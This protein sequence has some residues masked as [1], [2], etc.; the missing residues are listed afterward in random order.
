[1]QGLRIQRITVEGEGTG[2]LFMGP[3]DKCLEGDISTATRGYI[4][5]YEHESSGELLSPDHYLGEMN[6]GG[7]AL[8]RHGGEYETDDPLIAEQLGLISIDRAHPLYPLPPRVRGWGRRV[9][10]REKGRTE[11]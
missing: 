8:Y 2:Y 11:P 4:Q 9:T 3:T 10:C 5:G 7:F 1:M 6:G